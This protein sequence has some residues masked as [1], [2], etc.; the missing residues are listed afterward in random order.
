MLRVLKT[1]ATGMYAQQLY[2]DTISNNLANVNTTG[3]KKSQLQFQDLLYQTIR[4]TGSINRQ[5]TNRPAQLQIGYGTVPVAT[6]KIFSQGSIIQTNNPLDI[7]IEGEGFLRILMPNGTYAYTRDGSLK[8]STNG[9][10]VTSD[11]YIV[12][13]EISI[14]LDTT[15]VHISR[16]GEISVILQGDNT[17]INIGRLE[18]AYFMNPSGLENIGQNL[19]KE[20]LASGE[21]VVNFPGEGK[22]G[23]IRQGFLESSN[24]DVV[25]EMVNLIIAQRA[26]EINSKAIKTAE[27]ML[28]LA[29]DLKR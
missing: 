6:V 2:V 22:T 15:N 12:Q 4:T 29:N 28:R 24:V 21:A 13:P 8:L 27:E 5:G 3:F 25:E 9:S 18:L 1:A 23:T 16:T 19:Y 26:Y 7:G 10:L 20:T 17:P 14:P 11:G